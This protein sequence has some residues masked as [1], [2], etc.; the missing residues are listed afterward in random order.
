MLNS[1][2]QKS[3]LAVSVSCILGLAGCAT[4]F[5]ERLNWYGHHPALYTMAF[6]AAAEEALVRS[7][8]GRGYYEHMGDAA[9]T[10]VTTEICTRATFDTYL[11]RK[12]RG[13]YLIGGSPDP[14]CLNVNACAS[15]RYDADLFSD[16]AFRQVVTAAL[17]RPCDYL[18]PPDQVTHWDATARFGMSASAN[19]RILQ[20]DGKQVF[21]TSIVFDETDSILRVRFARGR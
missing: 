1:R 13:C 21:A 17:Q 12:E 8:T 4:P 15:F 14:D 9:Y 11:V 20:C 6:R 7:M 19:W 3:L 10:L 5:P 18:T 16:P 2:I